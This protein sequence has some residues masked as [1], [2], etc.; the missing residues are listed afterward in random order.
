MRARARDSTRK[1]MATHLVAFASLAYQVLALFLDR[2][3][4]APPA[5][6]PDRPA[7]LPD[8][9][10]T[11]AIRNRANKTMIMDKISIGILIKQI[12]PFCECRFQVA[13]IIPHQNIKNKPQIHFCHIRDVFVE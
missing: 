10:R 7:V 8:C 13:L 9:S 1:A 3:V 6:A 2:K 5:M 11:T 12:I 4:S